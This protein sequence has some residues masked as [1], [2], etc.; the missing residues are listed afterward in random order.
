MKITVIGCGRLGTPFAVSLAEMGHNVL[1]VETDPDTLAALQMGRCPFE[2]PG[3]EGY[4]RANIERGR[5]RFT[6]SYDD[7]AEHGDVHFLAV[8]TPQQNGSNAAD[9]TAVELS[10]NSLVKA[11]VRDAVVIGKS[12]VPVGTAKRM[13]ELAATV[14][15]PGV[16]VSIG[17][18]PDF[19]RESVSMSDALRP[20]RIIVGVDDADDGTVEKVAREIFAPFT[21]AGVELLVTN[22]VT[23]ELAK[24]AANA[25]LTTKISY[26]NFVDEVCRL[27]GADIDVVSRCLGLE[28]RIGAWGLTAGLGWGGSC[29]G[30]DLRAF[31]FRAKELGA[32]SFVEVLRQ[33]DEL[34]LARR[35]LAVDHA[36]E[37]IGGDLRG[38]SIAIWG[39]SFKPGMGDISDSP[40]LDVALRLC[41]RDARVFLFDPGANDLIRLKYPEIHVMSCAEDAVAPSQLL[42]VL[43]DW[44]EFA[45]IDPSS[46]NALTPAR[47]VID[48]RRCLDADKW[49]SAGW[50]YEPLGYRSSSRP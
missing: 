25:F 9:L 12:S 21:D 43:T 5:L 41:E 11:L 42:M 50:T 48:A 38:V 4:I 23:A 49:R 14:T 47:V 30:K 16:H 20:S 35:Q 24:G 45:R 22:Y 15:P 29:L 19:L 2:E 1:G 26:I 34:N 28:P 39:G 46:V 7:A 6:A 32:G 17:W 8:P 40:A 33:V 10:L 13:A 18:N 44:P 36:S 27:A 31:T 37:V 3:I